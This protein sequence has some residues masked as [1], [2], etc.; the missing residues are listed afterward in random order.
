NF[1]TIP[2]NGVPYT[3]DQRAIP[4]LENPSAR[5]VGEFNNNVY[6]NAID[7]IKNGDLDALNKIIVNNGKQP[8]SEVAFKRIRNDYFDF[9]EEVKEIIGEEIDATYGLKGIAAPWISST[10]GEIL[11]DGGAEQIL[12][13]I[14]GIYLELIGIILKYN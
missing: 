4:Y 5:H 11:M 12:T 10:T 14:N 2:E 9:S 1:T 3:Y 7:A 8:I 6:F 13:P